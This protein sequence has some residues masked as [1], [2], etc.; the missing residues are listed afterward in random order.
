MGD[1]VR[2]DYAENRG[3]FLGFGSSLPKPIRTGLFAVLASILLFGFLVYTLRIGK[4]TKKEVLA[5]GLIVGGGVSNL[6]DRWVNHG[7]VIDFLNLGIG[8][9]RT[10][11]LNVAD[12]AIM[13]GVV[14]YLFSHYDVRSREP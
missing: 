5:A 11:I 9:F 4:S 10:G 7:A 14:M 3:A 13:L 8:S 2:I 1:T 12:M 6:I